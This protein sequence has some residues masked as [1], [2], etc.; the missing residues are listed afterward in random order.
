MAWAKTINDN[1]TLFPMA[2][3]KPPDLVI[4]VTHRPAASYPTYLVLTLAQ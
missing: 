2:A 4:R 1:T 3:D